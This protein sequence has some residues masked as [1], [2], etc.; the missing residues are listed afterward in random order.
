[1]R[2]VLATTL[3]AV[4]TGALCLARQVADP[5]FDTTV[6]HPAYIDHHPRVAIDEAH[7]NLHKKD[8]IFKPFAALAQSDGYNVL[9]NTKPFTADV[10]KAFDVLVIS[11]A[12]GELTD[13]S[14]HS[15]PAFTNVECDAVYEWVRQGGALLLAADHVPMGDAAT[16]LAERLGVTLGRGI[17]FDTDSAAIDHDEITTIVFTRQNHLLGDHAIIRG[18]NA[19]E[20]LHRI[21]A[22]TGESMTVPK[23][24]AALL[25]TSPTAG[26]APTRKDLRPLYATNVEDAKAARRAE[27][28]N[29]PAGGK[30]MAVA[31]TLGRGRVVVNGEAGMLTAQGFKQ[32]SEDGVERFVDKMGMNVPGN[33]DRQYVLNVLHWLSGAL[34]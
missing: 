17:V 6:V 22:F 23:G 14:D 30:A 2:R 25:Q 7:H 26:E 28:K 13:D 15:A 21:V 5:T 10:L 32:K 9:T 1:M 20:R 4:V 34:K 16:S 31:Y 12:L 24:A 19:T 11:N 27:A 18:R 8:G 33:D 29:S 3:L